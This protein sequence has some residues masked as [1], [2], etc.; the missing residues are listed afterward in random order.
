MCFTRRSL[1]LI[2]SLLLIGVVAQAQAPRSEEDPR[3]IAPTVTGGT[4][5]FTVYDT[6]T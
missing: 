6:Q 3:N 1:C 5:L 4:G 2:F